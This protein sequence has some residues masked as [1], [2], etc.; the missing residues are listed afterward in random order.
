MGGLVPRR[1]LGLQGGCAAAVPRWQHP[2]AKCS[3]PGL[4]TF[5]QHQVPIALNPCISSPPL[6]HAV[7]S[8]AAA[9]DTD[10]QEQPHAAWST[11]DLELA[12]AEVEWIVCPAPLATST[13]AA[14]TAS[15]SSSRAAGLSGRVLRTYTETLSKLTGTLASLAHSL[16]YHRQQQEPAPYQPTLDLDRDITAAEAIWL[17]NADAADWVAIDSEAVS[18]A[19]AA[20][21]T[22]PAICTTAAPVG[23]GSVLHRGRW[24]ASAQRRLAGG[25][26]AVRGRMTCFT[27]RTK[28]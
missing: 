11:L 25:L 23:S 15:S 7:T 27:P 5:A 8:G 22:F 4:S 24:L 2:R 21:P 14:P 9:A 28:A 26:A 3:V 13:P 1:G 16:P 6:H 20:V 17:V 19:A 12:A 10:A 18:A